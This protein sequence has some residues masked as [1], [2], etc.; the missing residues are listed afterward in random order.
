[1]LMTCF[2]DDL[3]LMVFLNTRGVTTHAIV[4][5]TEKTPLGTNCIPFIILIHQPMMI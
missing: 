1:M 3:R 5:N 2:V 4:I